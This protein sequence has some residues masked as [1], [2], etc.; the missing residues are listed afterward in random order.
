MPTLRSKHEFSFQKIRSI[1]ISQSA[2]FLFMLYN[3]IMAITPQT[4][5]YLLKCPIEADNRNQINF[6]NATAQYNYFSSLPKLA[7][8]NCTYQRKDDVMRLPYHIDDIINY[9][10]VMYRNEAYSSKWFY[11][12]I[13][14][15]E[16]ASDH[17]TKVTIKTDV[18]QTWQFD[19]TFMRSFVERE[20]VNT[21]GVGDNLLNEQLPVSDYVVNSFSDY[22]FCSG[23]SD[24]YV[25]VQLS[26]LLGNMATQ[27]GS[28]KKIYG[29]IPSGCWYFAIDPNEPDA[30]S[31]LISAYDASGK[32]DAL[33][34][35]FLL[36]KA[37]APTAQQLSILIE[38]SG[39]QY[40]IDGFT[41]PDT[42]TYTV[43]G[44]KTWTRPT[45]LDGYTPKNNKLFTYPYS[46]LMVTNNG[47][48]DLIYKWEY[49]SDKSNCIFSLNGVPTQGISA[50]LTPTNYM[51]TTTVDGGYSWSI[52]SQNFPTISW[53]SDYYLNWQ[54]TNGTNAIV[55]STGELVN[56]L[57]QPAGSFTEFLGKAFN[58]VM[59]G[60]GDY[61][62]NLFTNVKNVITGEG[63]QAKVV[64][65]QAKGNVN[66]GDINFA[67]GKV[68]FTGYCMSINAETAKSIDD[69]FSM[70]GYLVNVSKVP[71]I[72]GRRYWNYVKT[73]GAN[74]EGNIPQGDMDEIKGMFDRGVTI[75]HD[76]S[77]YLDYTQNNTIV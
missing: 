40:A 24:C 45:K 66:S 70:F 20:H 13:T 59:G 65:D 73:I 31:Q 28:R 30:L 19:L 29:G 71:N 6:A 2:I 22:D 4:D 52:S 15:M 54:A 43:L 58:D 17:M 67:I 64:P 50:K 10:Y 39:T 68:G 14:D 42:T 23:L 27:Y 11:A 74:I 72:T 25:V 44:S 3:E 7:I 55:E 46:C 61:L 60:V 51:R 75:W 62:G 76:T 26:E 16:Y 32:S 77:H 9:N 38:V 47:G 5:I 49:T 48:S 18:Y 36:P 57:D 63:W 56:K 37:F 8:D 34:T 53:L 21:D 33:V 1:K 35:M 69:Y 12:F 41:L